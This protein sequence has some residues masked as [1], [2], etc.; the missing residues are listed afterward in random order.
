[1]ETKEIKS[2]NLNYV[3]HSRYCTPCD[4][5]QD[6]NK[7]SKIPDYAS[8]QNN[9]NTA[10]CALKLINHHP[11]A[12]IT[13]KVTV[14]TRKIRKF[15]SLAT[16]ACLDTGN[17][18]GSCLSKKA[19]ESLQVDIVP[20]KQKSVGLASSQARMKILGRARYPLEA[21]FGSHTTYL[22]P[23]VLESLAWLVAFKGL[24]GDPHPPRF[25]PLF[26]MYPFRINIGRQAVDRE[27]SI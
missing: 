10:Y 15:P 24:I 8:R 4:E 20:V 9:Y 17:L 13:K 16:A 3:C 2:Q 7:F 14:D 18:F 11:L 27:F 25:C 6:D 26:P 22:R 5:Y 19:A 1:M 23:F 21:R 12:P